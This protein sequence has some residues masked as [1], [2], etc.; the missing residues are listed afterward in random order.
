MV[1]PDMDYFDCALCSSSSG[2][3]HAL[4]DVAQQLNESGGIPSHVRA[5][6]LLQYLR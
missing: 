1:L 3:N 4:E 2:Y 6:D 5:P